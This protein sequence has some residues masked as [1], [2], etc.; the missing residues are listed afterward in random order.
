MHFRSV[1]NDEDKAN[2]WKKESFSSKFFRFVGYMAG[3]EQPLTEADFDRIHAKY[4]GDMQLAEREIMSEPEN[5]GPN[6]I[7]NSDEAPFDLYTL[8]KKGS[9]KFVL[10]SVCVMFTIVAA[11]FGT[12]SQS[13]ECWN[14]NFS[15]L[16]SGFLL[17]SGMR[18]LDS[19]ASS[20]VWLETFAV[21]LGVY[22]VLPI[23]GAVVLV[24]ILAPS[25]KSLRLSSVCLLTKRKGV[26]VIMIRVMNANGGVYTDLKVSMWAVLGNH[27]SDTGERYGEYTHLGMN[28]PEVLDTAQNVTHKVLPDS[29]LL[30]GGAIVV[31]DNGIPRF[32]HTKFVRI[33][34]YASANT[35]WG[36]DSVVAIKS[37]FDM[38]YHLVCAND[39]GEL[40]VWKSA[41]VHFP[42]E[43]LP[44]RGKKTNSL[45]LAKLSLYE[46][47]KNPEEV[48]VEGNKEVEVEVE[49]ESSARSFIEDNE[50]EELQES[51]ARSLIDDD[52]DDDDEEEEES[53]KVFPPPVP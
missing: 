11:I 51:S 29:P 28:C 45:D 1:W 22:L 10:L 43:F 37:W 35:T 25:H 34:L 14:E 32:D 4:N 33:R 12:L 53:E 18:S 49:E 24:R 27:D 3:L 30:R 46:W 36:G 9:S 8:A 15:L 44:S 26:P 47:K 42:K 39:K 41:I 17:L 23:S 40:P 7:F 38:S 19:N 50:Q 31:D 16:P 2:I 48:K 6:I 20:C 5:Y 13:L 21:M 52:D